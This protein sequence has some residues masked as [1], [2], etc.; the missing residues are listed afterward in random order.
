MHSLMWPP[1]HRKLLSIG[2]LGEYVSKIYLETK[3]RPRFIVQET[4]SEDLFANAQAEAR[5][6]ISA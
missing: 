5:H 4:T 6:R 3:R 1:V 2:V